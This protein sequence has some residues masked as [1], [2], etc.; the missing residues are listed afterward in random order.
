MTPAASTPCPGHVYSPRCSTAVRGQLARCQ[1]LLACPVRSNFVLSGKHAPSCAAVGI[2]AR[3]PAAPTQRSFTLLTVATADAPLKRQ[4][5]GASLAAELS[6]ATNAV[7]RT[8]F[9]IDGLVIYA[10][11]VAEIVC[12]A[13]VVA[14]R[15]AAAI[16]PS[17]AVVVDE[18]AE[19][20]TLAREARRVPGLRYAAGADAF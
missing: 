13:D 6:S 12:S 10:A 18:A 2:T 11:G 3:L 7:A 4:Y 15:A 16:D 5:A 9:A 17:P 1:V 8:A 19:G 14:E 20:F